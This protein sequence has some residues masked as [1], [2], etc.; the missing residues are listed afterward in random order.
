MAPF[1]SYFNLRDMTLAAYSSCRF[2]LPLLIEVARVRD[3]VA[4]CLHA[5]GCRSGHVGPRDVGAIGDRRHGAYPD[6]GFMVSRYAQDLRMI[7]D[8]IMRE[9]EAGRAASLDPVRR[10]SRHRF[11]PFLSL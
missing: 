8:V 11:F 9:I 2:R 1:V 7:E 4:N 5:G 10:N 6:R 3:S